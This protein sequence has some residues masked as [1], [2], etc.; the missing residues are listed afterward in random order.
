[1]DVLT[2]I[3]IKS[4]IIGKSRLRQSFSDQ[5]EFVNSLISEIFFQV[6]SSVKLNSDFGVISPDINIIKMVSNQ[7]AKFTFQ[8][9]AANLNDSLK[10]AIDSIW[11]NNFNPKWS[12]ILILMA[13]LPLI[14]EKKFKEFLDIVKEYD[15]GILP[16]D[17]AISKTTGTSGLFISKN[18]WEKINL[19]FGEN[20]FHKFL[21][22]IK[23]FDIPYYIHETDLGFDL[24]S[25]DDFWFLK[26]EHP[27]IFKSLIPKTFP[28]IKIS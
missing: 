27:S 2:L 6:I 18:I 3:P 17:F 22:Q 10:L 8:D 4:F 21:H 15:V 25:I 11:R 16:A 5:N 20:S 7:G 12:S 24:D 9:N 1:M 19:Q 28:E 13:D 23:M 26:K 14:N